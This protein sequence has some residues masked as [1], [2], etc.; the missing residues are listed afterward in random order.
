MNEIPAFSKCDKYL[1]KSPPTS[2]PGSR[3][4]GYQLHPHIVLL[5]DYQADT[6]ETSTY[7]LAPSDL[8]IVYSR[9]IAHKDERYIGAQKGCSIQGKWSGDR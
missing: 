5:V 6:I 7:P 2:K 4:R 1:P 8:L 9:N 3:H